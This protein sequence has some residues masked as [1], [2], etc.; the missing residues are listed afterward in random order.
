[1]TDVSAAR[2]YRRHSGTQSSITTP[3]GI[4]AYSTE[5]SQVPSDPSDKIIVRALSLIA[6]CLLGTGQLAAQAGLHLKTNPRRESGIHLDDPSKRRAAGRSHLLIQYADTPTDDQLT[7]LSDRGV[8]VLSYI[9]DFGF[10]A[11]ADDGTSLEG[12]DIQWAGRVAAS[13]KISPIFGDSQTAVVEFFP[14]VDPNDARSIV[15][16]AQLQIQEHPDLRPNHLLVALTL[17]QARALA[18][19]E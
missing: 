6:I 7:V 18:E 14:D 1:M 17:G 13:D 3:T 15:L 8:A 2:V 19:W 10:A 11:A 4:G 12:L 16:E 5:T 9:P